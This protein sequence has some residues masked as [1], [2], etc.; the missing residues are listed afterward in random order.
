M[1]LWAFSISRSRF[2]PERSV[3]MMKMGELF[4]CVASGM[5]CFP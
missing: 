3:P 2:V 5:G 4:V 1:A